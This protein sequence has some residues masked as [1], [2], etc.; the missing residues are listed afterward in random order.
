[1]TSDEAKLLM[2]KWSIGIEGGPD[3]LSDYDIK[4]YLTK[5]MPPV[6]QIGY[7]VKV[8]VRSGQLNHIAI[9]VM[10]RDA[11]DKADA[12]AKEIL[13]ELVRVRVTLV[14]LRILCSRQYT[15]CESCKS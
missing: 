9:E 8:Q 3:I 15:N 2:D 10:P 4:T 11:W 6:E 14:M 1:M 5:E 12:G 13:K 7:A